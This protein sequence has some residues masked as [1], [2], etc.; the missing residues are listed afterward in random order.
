MDIKSFTVAGIKELVEQEGSPSRELLEAMAA[1]SRHGVQVLY[2]RCLADRQSEITRAKRFAEM[3]DFE[4]SLKKPSHR[5]VAGIDEAGRGPLAGPVV[6][7]AV[8]LSGGFMFSGLDDSKKLSPAKR[9]E[10]DAQIKDSAPA[11]AVGMATVEE[12]E[13]HNIHHASL[14]AMTRALNGLRLRPDLVLIDGRF[15][16]PG[17]E[18]EQRA[19]IGG[20]GL[21]PSIAAASVVAKVARDQLMDVLHLLYP[22]YGFDRHRGYGTPFHLTAI[23]LHGPCPVHRRGFLP[24]KEMIK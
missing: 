14:L 13:I 7:A 8:I 2:K 16:L 12:I 19:V 23:E 4:Q 10:L 17:L 5:L 1:D 3:R 20:D 24:V 21:C 9:Q 6:A 15:N 11:W 22:E 18:T